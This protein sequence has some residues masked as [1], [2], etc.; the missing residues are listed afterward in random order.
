ME[1]HFKLYYPELWNDIIYLNQ[2]LL[3]D[4][5]VIMSCVCDVFCCLNVLQDDVVDKSGPSIEDLVDKETV[6]I[7]PYIDWEPHPDAED[8]VST[9]NHAEYQTSID[10]T[11]F[12]SSPNPMFDHLLYSS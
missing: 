3:E 9:H 4:A 5:S 8:K 1:V 2:E 10:S 6:D 7:L 11:C 12:I